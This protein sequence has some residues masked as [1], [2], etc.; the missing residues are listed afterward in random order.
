MYT[1][2]DIDHKH[3]HYFEWIKDRDKNDIHRNRPKKRKKNIRKYEIAAK[4][5]PKFGLWFTL[6][7]V[8]ITST[9]CMREK[10][11]K[12]EDNVGKANEQSYLC[13]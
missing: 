2:I 10:Q 3:N 5:L 13:T 4:I 8:A 12:R 11:K 1:H 9:K 6:R 7:F